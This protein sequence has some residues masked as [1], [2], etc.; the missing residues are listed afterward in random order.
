VALLGIT[1]EDM[2]E[3]EDQCNMKEN[4]HRLIAASPCGGRFEDGYMPSYRD[5]GGNKLRKRDQVSD[6][7]HELDSRD[8]VISDVTIKKKGAN[9]INGETAYG[10]V[11]FDLKFTKYIPEVGEKVKCVLSL[12]G[13]GMNLP[14]KCQ[15]V[16]V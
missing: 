15:R 16:L 7:S 14:W 1:P 6:G 8:R 9:Y 2:D 11:Y 13:P 4:Y 10:K 3:F 5:T 12:K